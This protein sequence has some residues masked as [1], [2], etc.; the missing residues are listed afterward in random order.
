MRQRERFFLVFFIFILISVVIFLLSTGGHLKFAS[1]LLEKIASPVGRSAYSAFHKLPFVSENEQAKKMNDK[2]LSLIAQLSEIEK[3][4]R[5]NSA[6]L[7]QFQTAK[8]KSKNI[9][10]ANIVGVPSFIPGITTPAN[11]ILDKGHEDKVKVG[12]GVVLKNNLI[13]KVIK[14]SSH[15]S[16]VEIIVNSSSSFTAKTKRDVLG[17]IKGDGKAMIFSNVLL[18]ENIKVGDLVTTKGDMTLEGIGYPQDLIIGKIKSIDKNPSELFQ[19][20]RVESFLDFNKLSTVFIILAD[21]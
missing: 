2:N 12:Y 17:V 4:K 14:T 15:L 21:E 16:K 8:P 13:G 9:L 5:E 6:L 20:A 3:L 19:K 18:S 11:F 1:S 7:D 10:P